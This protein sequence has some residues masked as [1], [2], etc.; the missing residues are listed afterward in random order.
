MKHVNK[1]RKKINYEIESKIFLD[2]RNIVTARLFKKLN[3][4]MLNSFN[5]LNSVDFSYKLKLSETMY[6]HDVFHFELFHLVIDDFLPDQKN[7]SLKSIMINDENEWKIDDI[8]NSWWYWKQL[9]YQVKWKNYDNDL[10]W[11]NIDDNEFMNAQN[12]VDD[13]HTQYF[14]QAH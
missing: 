3:N 1:H 4:K 9:Q 6:I 5:M 8:L 14:N 10:N 12:V 11:Y 2:E 13:F 7:D